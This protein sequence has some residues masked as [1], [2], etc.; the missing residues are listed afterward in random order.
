MKAR[1]KFLRILAAAALLPA[2]GCQHDIDPDELEYPPDVSKVGIA[3]ASESQESVEKE[4]RELENTPYPP[5]RLEGGDRFRI[6]VYNEEDLGGNTTATTV[7]T[8]DGYLVMD[9]V[10]PVLVKDL[11]IVEAT[12]KLEDE[13]KK[14]VKYPKVSLSPETIQGKTATLLGAVREPGEYP[15]NVDTRLSD[16]IAKGKGYAVGILDDNTVDL[17]DI[18]NAYIIRNGKMLPVDFVEAIVMG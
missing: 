14:L 8:P 2:C 17:A 6:K 18:N 9:A 12:K 16:L 1:T 4:L 15:V 13:L 3:A 11:T 7:V 5:Y 10:G